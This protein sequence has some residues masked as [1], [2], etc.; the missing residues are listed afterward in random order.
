MRI[1]VQEADFDAGAELAALG[2]SDASVGGVACFVGR[3]R[4]VNEG[5]AVRGMFLEHYPAMTAR[6][7]ADIVEQAKQR[8]QVLDATVIHRV[9]AL[10]PLDQIVFVGVASA[11]RGDAFAAC[12]F[13]MDFL[14]TQAPF[15]KKETTP[16][17]ERWVEARSSD[18]RAAER[19]K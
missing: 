17:G 1:L 12:E 14:K 2:A 5:S 8:W 3:V 16:E 10:Q 13:I 15:W 19:W 11:H 4:D 6:A 9:G 18:D 7:L